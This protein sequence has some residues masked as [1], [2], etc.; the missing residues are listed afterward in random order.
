MPRT[1]QS[2]ETKHKQND[3]QHANGLFLRKVKCLCITFLARNKAR[4]L[5]LTSFLD[6]PD[7]TCRNGS[8]T[9]STGGLLASRS[10]DRV[11]PTPRTPPVKHSKIQPSTRETLPRTIRLAP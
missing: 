10:R 8:S 5:C 4:F 6:F 1:Q 3:G 2:N 9:L 11:T 7:Y